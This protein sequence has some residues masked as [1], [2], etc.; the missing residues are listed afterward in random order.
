MKNF[1]YYTILFFIF[2]LGCT[3]SFDSKQVEGVI[4]EGFVQ[5][6]GIEVESVSCPKDIELKA[7]NTFECVLKDMDANEIAILV[8]QK[9][10][11]GNITWNANQGLISLDQLAQSIENNIKQNQDIDV[12]GNCGDS[13]FKIAHKDD[14]FECSISDPDGRSQV[15]K[16][17][18]SDEE[19]NVTWETVPSEPQDKEE[20]SPEKPEKSVPKN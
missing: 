1:I 9:D 11:Q 10:D 13:K 20:S 17:T 2:I 5:K 3:P 7:N 18:V 6:T 16:V 15:V 12:K 19:G 14:V 4:Q 8:T